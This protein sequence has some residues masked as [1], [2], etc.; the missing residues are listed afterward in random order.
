M[1][2]KLI[3]ALLSC[4]ILLTLPV[5]AA[6]KEFDSFWLEFKQALQKNDQQKIVSLTKTP[7][8]YQDKNLDKTHL[9]P[10][11]SKIFTPKV[12][13]CLIKQRPV[14]DSKEGYSGFCGEIIYIFSKVNGHYL[15]T[16]LGVND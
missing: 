6:D 8:Y 16:D 2:S 4:L 12:R 9:L 7:F 11:L 3:T 1:R 13:K 10:Q 14:G 5:H 15:F